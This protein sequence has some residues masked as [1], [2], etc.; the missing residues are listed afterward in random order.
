MG[1]LETTAERIAELT[2]SMGAEQLA[3]Q[4]APGKWSIHEIVAHLA[5]QELVSLARCR[6]ILFENNPELIG[7]D[8]NNWSKGWRKEEE[9]FRETLNRF[10]VLR[11]SLLRL[12]R[13]CTEADLARTGNHMERGAITL[14]SFP[15][16]LAGHDI[17][18]LLQIERLS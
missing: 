3:A 7:Y 5:D 10:R 1:V 15:P 18:H 6:W 2:R 11:G 12:L 17:N 14:G 8:Q 9:P 13:T 16:H 4:P